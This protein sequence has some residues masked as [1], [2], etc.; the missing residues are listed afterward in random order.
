MD[1]YPDRMTVAEVSA[2]D[3]VATSA[4]YVGSPDLLHT[5][6]GFS[7]LTDR[8]GAKVVRDALEQFEAEPGEGWP[9]WAFSNHDVP[10]VATRW[11]RGKGPGFTRMLVA[12]LCSVRGTPFLYQGEELGLPEAEVPYERIQDPYGLAFWPE[13]KGRD[14]CRTPMPWSDRM[15]HGGFTEGEPWLPVPED[16]RERAVSAQE[17]DP[18]SMLG[19]TRAFLAW[20]RGQ[21]ALRSGD[22]RFLDAPDDVVLF[23]RGHG[24]ERIVAAFNLGGAPVRLDLG[25]GTRTIEAPGAHGSIEGGHVELPPHGWAFATTSEGGR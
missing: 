5:A 9:A 11:G 8:F 4:L 15:P 7:L 10:R 23:E 6:Y 1:R 20:R 17:G 2:D 16:H 24:A 14:G 21:A 25:E 18:G 13:F 12:L 22:I 19:F 3:S